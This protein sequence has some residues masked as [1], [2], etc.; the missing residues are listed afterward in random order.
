M[1]G[2]TIQSAACWAHNMPYRK[3]RDYS[4]LQLQDYL[5]DVKVAYTVPKQQL[6]QLKPYVTAPYYEGLA[7][8]AALGWVVG[9]IGNY[10]VRADCLDL[11]EMSCPDS[12][13]SEEFQPGVAVEY[14]M[15]ETEGENLL[16]VN[17]LVYVF[18]KEGNTPPDTIE[19]FYSNWTSIGGIN[20]PFKAEVLELLQDVDTGRTRFKY[21]V[22]LE[23]LLN[24]GSEFMQV[25]F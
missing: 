2:V 17:P 1:S 14:M 22:K 3:Y 12:D 6:E 13:D 18:F 11:N 20:L 25:R 9:S 10:P 7:E 16:T 23:D 19:S 15:L 5:K 8:I 24:C 21:R 4:Y